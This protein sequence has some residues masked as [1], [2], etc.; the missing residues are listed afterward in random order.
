MLPDK[1]PWNTASGPLD[2]EYQGNLI[3]VSRW[4]SWTLAV[5]LF[6]T[7]EEMGIAAEKREIQAGSTIAARGKIA[8]S[9]THVIAHVLA[10]AQHNQSI[11]IG[12]LSH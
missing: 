12:V 9:A 4:E 1:R 6:L 10:V 11:A 3:T 7:L 5:S 8:M 2:R